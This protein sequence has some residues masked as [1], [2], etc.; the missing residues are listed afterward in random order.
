MVTE[1]KISELTAASSVNGSMEFETNDGGTSKKVTGAQIRTYVGGDVTGFT[2]RII[3]GDMRI[4]QRAATATVSTDAKYYATDRWWGTGTNTAG[5]FTLAQSTS[6]PPAGFTHFLRSTVTT[7]DSSLAA[8]DF[9]GFGQSIEG[10]NVADLGLGTAAAQS[11]TLSF[12]V[13]SSLTG[14]FTGALNSSTGDLSFPFT[15][16]ISA[17]NTWE[18][19]TVQVA[20]PTSGTFSQADLTGLQLWIILAIG[21]TWAG[22]AG[23]WAAAEKYGASGAVNVMATN[24]A[25]FD[26]TGVQLEAGSVATP[27]FA[28]R[29]YGRELMM[30]QRYY[31]TG[32]VYGWPRSSDNVSLASV[33]LPVSLRATPTVTIADGTLQSS[34]PDTRTTQ[35][36]GAYKT[37]T[38]AS[39][40]WYTT[41]TASAEL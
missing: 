16:T 11:M 39:T 22:T 8:G 32:G 6:T 41:F 9:Y 4:N 40:S 20:A 10:Y 33:Y 35:S 3:N 19:K 18:T 2:N 25:T 15:Y 34:A 13:R 23:S 36:F 29:D 5:V 28:R 7:T 38:S 1:V 26:I 21:S 14:T 12:R 31:Q 17:A 24:G 37:G 27:V 30:C